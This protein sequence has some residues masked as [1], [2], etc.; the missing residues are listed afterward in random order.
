MWPRGTGAH[1]FTGPTYI[2]D[3]DVGD[4]LEVR[5]KDIQLRVD[6]GFNIFRGYMA[7]IPE[8]Y[9]YTRL[10]H[11]PLDQEAGV[12]RMACGI[13]IPIRP[14]FGQLAVQPAP[15][16]G[17]QNFQRATRVRRQPRLQRI[18]CRLDYLPTGLE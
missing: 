9:P 3:A 13:E 17:Q 2:R 10:I 1:I 18:D 14:F 7:T 16:F 8:D 11:V 4:V 5:I 15:Q 6:W 12:A